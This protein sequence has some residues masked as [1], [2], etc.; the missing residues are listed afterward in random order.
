MMN[1]LISKNNH[2]WIIGLV[3]IV[4][5][6]WVR[7][8]DWWW[9]RRVDGQMWFSGQASWVDQ[10]DL[11]VYFRVI[12]MG[13]EG[14]G[15]R[16]VNVADLVG[17]ETA[18]LYPVYTFIGKVGALFSIDPASLFH[19]SGLITSMGLLLMLW[20]F[21]GLFLKRTSRLIGWLW[22]LF[23]S[24]I[25]WLYYPEMIFPDLGVPIFTLW[26]A[27]RAPHEA[28]SVM[29]FL[30][31]LGCGYLYLRDSFD[32]RRRL[33][34]VVVGTLA[35]LL[36]HPQMVLPAGLILSLWAGFQIKGK[37]V[38]LRAGLYLVGA[39]G[40]SLLLF[41]GVMGSDLLVGEVA[42][43]LRAQGTYVFPWWYWL[44]GWGLVGVLALYWVIRKLQKDRKLFGVYAVVVWV[45]IQLCLFYFPGI[46]Y[47]GM[48]IRGI[49]V[50]VV[51]LAVWGLEYLVKQKRW[52]FEVVGWLILLLSLGNV[53]FI[54]QQR[55]S[56]LH[57]PRSIYV[58]ADEGEVWSYLE[59]NSTYE[60]G[61]IGS[62][63]MANMALG[64]SRARPYAG[65][66]PLTPDFYVRYEE[67]LRFYQQ[68][69]LDD[70]AYVW[71]T[72]RAIDWVLFGPDEW[73]LTNNSRLLYP[74]LIP[75][76]ESG[77]VRLYRIYK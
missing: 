7:F 46:P 40:F 53:I 34:G 11:N 54:F 58:S 16:I 57:Q 27:L 69:M 2:G 24:G 20:W 15:F 22:C 33:L 18:I 44:A 32:R 26:S 6:V 71:A 51:I 48:L 73:K 25:G 23:A 75:V 39:L 4:A 77:E 1:Q 19:I 65:H 21:L 12:R 10:I 55:M 56:G 31:M 67:V 43:G 5:Q 64:Q 17:V 52:N 66:Y 49:W 59:R 8:P 50:P 70:E 3:L 13:M 37:K 62:Y 41:Y 42:Q 63:R 72:E 74:W 76:V 47:Q 29:G 60:Q 61:I 35:V 38:A 28:V 9:G 45:G 68:E 30:F 36:N 14:G